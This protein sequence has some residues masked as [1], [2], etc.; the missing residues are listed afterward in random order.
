MD[1]NGIIELFWSR[2]EQAITELAEKYGN[3][4]RKVSF[5]ILHNYED[6]EECVNDTYLGVWNTIPPQKPNPLM[7]YVIR[8]AKNLSINRYIYNKAEKRNSSLD[9]CFEELKDCLP[10]VDV[11]SSDEELKYIIE[12]FLDSL[13]YESRVMFVRRYWSAESLK[14]I[15]ADMGISENSV[16]VR[17]HRTRNKLKNYLEKEGAVI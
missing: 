6:S 3:L 7:P 5:N 17:I 16:A 1:D 15:A 9:L 8:I 2:S 10:T 4:C 14:E 13:S 12:N 11:S